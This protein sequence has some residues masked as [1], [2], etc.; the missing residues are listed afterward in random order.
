[1]LTRF[2]CFLRRHP[3]KAVDAQDLGPDGRVYSLV[4]WRCRC[5]HRIEGVRVYGGQFPQR[6]A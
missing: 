3:L 5:A 4:G 1:M 2:V 6:R